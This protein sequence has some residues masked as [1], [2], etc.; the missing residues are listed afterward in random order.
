MKVKEVSRTACVAWSPTQQYP[1]YIAGATAANQLSAN[2]E[3]V[4][5]KLFC[6]IWNGGLKLHVIL[7]EYLQF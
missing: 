5:L 3:Y 4:E 6:E 7:M 2:F 1:V